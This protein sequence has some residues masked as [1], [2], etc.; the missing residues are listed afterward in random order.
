[1][2]IEGITIIE[3]M[4]ELE[5]QPWPKFSWAVGTRVQQIYAAKNKTPPP[6]DLRVKTAGK[7]RHCFAIYPYEMRDE[8]IEVIR[9]YDT[10]MNRPGRGLELILPNRKPN[11]NV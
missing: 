4:R 9:F 2:N 6:K 1:M 8:I 5:I 7:G 3:V 10:R 11:V